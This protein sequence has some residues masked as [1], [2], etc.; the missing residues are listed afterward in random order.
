MPEAI[1][2]IFVDPDGDEWRVSGESPR[3]LFG[4]FKTKETAIENGRR[5]A[6]NFHGQ[7]IVRAK[8]EA[9]DFAE[10]YASVER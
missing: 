7:M 2:T 9:L 6:K 1:H 4:T 3:Q 8:A 10:D 5:L